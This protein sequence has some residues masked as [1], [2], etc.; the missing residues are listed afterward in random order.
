MVCSLSSSAEV[1]YAVRESGNVHSKDTRRIAATGHDD[2][3]SSAVY[4]L[5]N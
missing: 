5:R 3:H 1:K 4:E 2:D